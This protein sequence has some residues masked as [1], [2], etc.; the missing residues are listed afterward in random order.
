MDK[1]EVD[2]I[3]K[4]KFNYW[5]PPLDEE[6]KLAVLNWN[7][8]KVKHKIAPWPRTLIFEEDYKEHYIWKGE[9]KHDEEGGGLWY[10]DEKK[11]EAQKKVLGYVLK[12]IGTNLLS[13]KGVTGISLPVLVFS[14]ESNL[15][16]L[17]RS[18]AYAPLVLENVAHMEDAVEQMKHVIVLS[19]THSLIY[20]DM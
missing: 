20:M 19:F 17:A 3:S 8:L 14:T 4:Y 16:R 10:K 13:G 18:L 9:W 6:T 5:T 11:M 15:E 2:R 12:K 7:C 1:D